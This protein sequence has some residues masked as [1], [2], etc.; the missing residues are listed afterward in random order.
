MRQLT[1]GLVASAVASLAFG[2]GGCNK[3]PADAALREA[4]QA[5]EAAAP[6]IGRYVPEELA[7]L[8]AEVKGARARFD[9]GH[10]TDALKTARALPVR[11]EA[12]VQA[13]RKKKDELTAAWNELSV[14]LPATIEPLAARVA[15]LAAGKRLPPAGM[16]RTMLATVQ[17]DLD[18]ATRAWT[19]AQTAFQGGDVLRAVRTARDANA[20][21]EALA[22]LVGLRPAAAPAAPKA[23]PT[24]APAAAEVP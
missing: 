3:G 17:T 15:E 22:G 23:K 16:D 9:E 6:E 12:A 13:A 18:G 19:E 20:K 5:L 24:P 1:K 21:A 14:A 2:G 10:Y 8:N 11:I 4:V 7:A